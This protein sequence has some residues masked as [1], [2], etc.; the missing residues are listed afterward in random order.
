[1]FR[2]YV[3][4][5]FKCGTKLRDILHKLNVTWRDKSPGQSTIYRWLQEFRNETRNSFHDRAKSGRPSSISEKLIQHVKDLIE[6]NP[7]QTISEICRKLETRYEL[8]RGILKDHLRMTKVC[9]VWVP[10][11]LTQKNKTDRVLCCQSLLQLF[12][13]FT[14]PQLLKQM[15]II[16]ETWITFEPGRSRKDSRYWHEVG[17]PR[18][19]I[20]QTRQ[21]AKKTMA[22]IAM[23]GDKKFYAETTQPNEKVNAERYIE[24][25]KNCISKFGKERIA[26]RLDHAS[27]IWQHDNARPH[28]SLITKAFFSS[29]GIRM[30][31]QSP[32]SPDLNQLDRWVNKSIKNATKETHFVNH[33]EVKEFVR[34]H[35]QSLPESQFV[36]EL[37]KLKT[38]CHHVIRCNGNYTIS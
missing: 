13:E 31:F 9:S 11:N 37:N 35:L 14:I 36:D 30:Q 7:R 16:D 18:G 2:F 1:M 23:T 8:T 22:L 26:K 20:S 24:F 25:S 21:T 33:D 29:K 5:E 27:I 10:Y 12:D 32:Y 4:T 3:Y 38:H 19:Q 6:E 15:V 28:V 34:R 17:T